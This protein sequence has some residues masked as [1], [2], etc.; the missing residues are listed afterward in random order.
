RRDHDRLLLR[1]LAPPI[2][3]PLA[4]APYPLENEIGVQSA[5][6][7]DR[8]DRHARRKSL[9]DDPFALVEASRSPP[10]PS[11]VMRRHPVSTSDSGGHLIQSRCCPTGVRQITL[12][13]HT[14]FQRPKRSGRG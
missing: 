3:P 9:L 5:P 2:A 10:L 14:L 13:L 1:S 7:R 8:R 6:T 12:T 4:R 11:S